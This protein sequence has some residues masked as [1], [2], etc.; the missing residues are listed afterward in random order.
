MRWPRSLS[1]VLLVAALAAASGCGGGGD[2][3]GGGKT[4]G[5]CTDV[6]APSPREDSNHKAPTSGLDPSKT[7]DVAVETNCGTFTITLD[8][9]GS[10]KT[11]ASFASLVRDGEG[12]A[13]LYL[14]P[15]AGLRAWASA[16]RTRGVTQGAPRIGPLGSAVLVAGG[17]VAGPHLVIVDTHAARGSRTP[18]AGTIAP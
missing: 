10:P 7:Y 18:A 17:P 2:S 1:A 4:S 3:G 8:V 13:A 15:A 14:R 9:K 16:A 5:G 6:S 12:P 11:S